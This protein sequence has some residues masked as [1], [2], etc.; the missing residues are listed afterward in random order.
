MNYSII[1]SILG[2]AVATVTFYPSETPSGYKFLRKEKQISLSSRQLKL[3]EGRT[4]R[5]LRADF[6]VNESI[7]KLHK[8]LK[9]EKLSRQWMKGVQDYSTIS[10]ESGNSWKVYVQYNVP[11]PLSNQDCII[12]YSCTSSNDGKSLTINMNGQ[13]DYLPRK[14]GVERITHM[15]G[16]WSINQI[17]NLRCKVVYTVFSAQKPK[18]PRWA[19]DPLIQQNLISSLSGLKELAEK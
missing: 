3:P 16:C 19:T 15:S 6:I 17:S 12:N 9:D 4:T 18:F 14:E 10:M 11:W 13:P 8:V 7:E 5:E 2:F 1:L